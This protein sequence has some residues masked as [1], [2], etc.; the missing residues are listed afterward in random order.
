MPCRGLLQP[1]PPARFHSQRPRSSTSPTLDRCGWAWWRDPERAVPGVTATSS[2]CAFP[3]PAPPVPPPV[4]RSTAAGGPGGGIQSV[5]GGYCNLLHQSNARPLRVGLVEGSIACRGL[6]QPPPARFHS[7]RPRSSTSPTLHRCG[8][9]WWRDPSERAVPGVTAT[10]SSCAFPLPA[11]PFLHQ[12]DAPPL[13]EG[14]IAC[15]GLLQPPPPARFHSQRPR[16]S[17]SPT[18]D[19]CGWAWWRDP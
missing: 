14:S 9:A 12:S 18:L 2:S 1:P 4:R 3:L 10:S 6:L 5:P 11:P 17:T 7:Q 15:R 13:V 8:W 19:R 16:S